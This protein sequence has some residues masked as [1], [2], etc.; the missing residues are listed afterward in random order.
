MTKKRFESIVKLKPEKKYWEERAKFNFYLYMIQT[1]KI[2][3]KKA[4]SYFIDK[5]PKFSIEMKFLIFRLWY[6]IVSIPLEFVE[7]P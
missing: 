2:Y 5:Q 1:E 7:K 4:F 3:F 6:W